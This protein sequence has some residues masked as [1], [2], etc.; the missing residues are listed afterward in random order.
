[1]SE[2]AVLTIAVSTLGARIEALRDWA[3][4]PRVRYLVLWQQP[5][6]AVPGWPAN[7]R[8]LP[9]PDRGVTRSRNAAIEH[10]A[11]PWL[12]FMDDD[13]HI[14]PASIETLLGEL[15]GWGERDVRICSVL[16]PDGRPLKRRPD[17]SA[18]GRG[19]VLSVG[20]IQ[21]VAHAGWLRARDVRFPLRLGAGATYPVCDEPVFLARALRAGASVRHADRITVVHPELSSGHA[22]DRAELVRSRAIA[23]YEIFGFPLCVGASLGFWMRHARRIGAQWPALFHYGRAG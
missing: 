22:L 2:A 6:A 11:T 17:G 18:Y 9:L 5:G 20:T 14:P 15:P 8:V 1:M 10:C 7:V 16:L 4:D 12:W 13:V 3:F 23:F 19:A 21:I